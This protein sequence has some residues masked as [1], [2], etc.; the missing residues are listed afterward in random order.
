MFVTTDESEL[1]RRLVRSTTVGAM[2]LYVVLF[3][4]V[5]RVLATVIDTSRLHLFVRSFD[6]YLLLATSCCVVKDES[7]YMVFVR[8]VIVGFFMLIEVYEESICVYRKKNQKEKERTKRMVF[9]SI[10]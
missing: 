1:Q 6:I 8:V 9:I 7:I 3:F 5:S 2:R 10:Q 4:C